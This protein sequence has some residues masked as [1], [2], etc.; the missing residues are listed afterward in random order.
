MRLFSEVRSRRVTFEQ[1]W[2]EAAAICWPEYRNSFSFGHVRAP[3]IKY[4]EYQIASSGS[5]ASHRFMS[6]CDALL[7][8]WNMMWSQIRAS[9]T[10]LMKDRDAKLYFHDLTQC[11]WS[12]R[13]RPESNFMGQQQ[14]N[15]QA[16]GVFGNQAMLV[17]QLDPAPGQFAPGLRY[18]SMSPG[19]VYILQ[20]HQGRVDGFIRH[21]RWTAR[22]AYQ[23]WKGDIPPVL[24]AALQVN[25]QQM[26]DFLQFVI[27]RTDYDPNK[28]FSPQGKPWS[29]T[30]ISVTG[31]KILEEGGYRTFPLPVGRYMQAPEE[32]YGRGPGQMV[33]PTLKTENAIEATYLKQGHRAGDPTYLIGDDGLMDFKSHP[34]AYNY[35]GFNED[36]GR[37]IVG[38]LPT[39]DFQVN[40]K[41]LDRYDSIIQDAFL[42]KLFPLLFDSKGQPRSPREVLERAQEVG[43]F[44]APTLGR[45]YGEYLGTMIDRELDLIDYMKL[46]PKMPQS[47]KEAKG[48]FRLQYVYTSPLARMM[49]SQGISG[50]M[51]TVDLAKEVSEATGDPSHLDHFSF[52]RALPAIADQQFAPP[53]WMATEQEMADLAKA[54]EQAAERDRQVKELPGKAAIMKAQAITA[55]AQTGGN[56]GGTLSGSPEGSM[57]MLPGQAEPGGRAFGQPGPQPA[58]GPL[59]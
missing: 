17:D 27:P 58:Q 41:M 50:F 38:V 33:L 36:T 46:G 12:H 54:R 56:T 10:D 34:G 6:I 45:Q 28:M 16:L 25:S 7:T 40:E 2:E 26:Y 11:V 22:Q 19:E 43:I 29:S 9:N 35:G 21:F 48:S 59:P 1:Q 3:G 49:E 15:W 31:L 47:V 30:Y 53:D 32:E 42:T 52:K 39:G 18:M 24:Y 57:P 44:L 51:R 13:Y 55:K 5:I 8:P 4:T 14:Q 20:N 37:M 23:R